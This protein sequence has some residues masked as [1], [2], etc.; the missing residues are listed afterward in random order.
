V[1]A[2]GN[3]QQTKAIKAINETD[4]LIALLIFD[5]RGPNLSLLAALSSVTVSVRMAVEVTAMI[6]LTEQQQQALDAAP[7]PARV[8]DPRTHRAY[9]LVTVE[10]YERLKDLLEPGTLT[11]DER[12]VIVQ[13]VWRRANWDDPRMDDYDALEPRKEP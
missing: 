5:F 13:G 10:L 4:V 12:R 9:V 3:F 11:A 2:A 6:E 1:S 8:L 7:L